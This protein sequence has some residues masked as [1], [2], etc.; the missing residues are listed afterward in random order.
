MSDKPSVAVAEDSY[1]VREA[2]TQLLE[3]D[4][5]VDVVAVAEDVD[6][7]T[8]AIER[9]RPDVVLTDIEMPPFAGRRGHPR[10]RPPARDAPRRSAS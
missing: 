3:S 8:A 4:P 2:L 1:L 10:R 5:E 6:A 7:L 9:E